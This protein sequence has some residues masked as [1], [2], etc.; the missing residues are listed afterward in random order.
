MER[1]ERT[2]GAVQGGENVGGTDEDENKEGNISENITEGAT[3]TRSDRGRYTG[4]VGIF[5]VTGPDS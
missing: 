4:Q 2:P 1:V 3:Q 5:F